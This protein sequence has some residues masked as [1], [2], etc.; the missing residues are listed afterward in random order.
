MLQ[1]EACYRKRHATGRG[2]LQEDRV[3]QVGSTHIQELLGVF[4]LC[5][6]NEVFAHMQI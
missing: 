2:M 5:F 4:D 1:E 6:A 3:V